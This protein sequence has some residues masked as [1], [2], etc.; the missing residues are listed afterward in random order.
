MTCMD[1]CVF[2]FDEV[3]S[4]RWAVAGDR[5]L[6]GLHIQL[7]YRSS[8][9]Q[10]EESNVVGDPTD[11]VQPPLPHLT[12]IPAGH[13]SSNFNEEPFKTQEGPLWYLDCD[14]VSSCD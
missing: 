2:P 9:R 5:I 8:C 4:R 3:V 11:T 7:S 1:T 10:H 6:M 13:S 12:S 14:S